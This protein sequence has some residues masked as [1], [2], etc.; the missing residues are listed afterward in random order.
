[1]PWPLVY[2]LGCCYLGLCGTCIYYNTLTWR[3][4]NVDVGFLFS[5]LLWVLCLF[6]AA[7]FSHKRAKTTLYLRGLNFNYFV[8]RSKC[9][10][11]Q[12]KNNFEQKKMPLEGIVFLMRKQHGVGG[13]FW[14]LPTCHFPAPNCPQAVP[15]HSDPCFFA[16]DQICWKC[17]FCPRSPCYTPNWMLVLGQEPQSLFKGRSNTI[18]RSRTRECFRNCSWKRTLSVCFIYLCAH[19]SFCTE[20]WRPSHNDRHNLENCNVTRV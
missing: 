2:F 18:C 12:F 4:G 20:K 9:M 7:A 19:F 13:V 14:L 15:I 11:E 17:L 1:M 10:Q 16:S 3:R 5:V 8:F 6:W